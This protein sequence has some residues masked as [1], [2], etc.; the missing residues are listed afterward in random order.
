MNTEPYESTGTNY[1]FNGLLLLIIVIGVFFRYQ[2]L[3]TDFWLDE[4]WALSLLERVSSAT[5]IITTLHVDNNHILSSLSSYLIGDTPDW[6][7]Y[8]L[9]ALVAG[10]LVPVLAWAITS[11]LSSERAGAAFSFS[12]ALWS[13]VPR[14]VSF[15]DEESADEERDASVSSTCSVFRDVD[16][17]LGVGVASAGP[18]GTEFRIWVSWFRSMLTQLSVLNQS[19]KKIYR[20]TVLCKRKALGTGE[21][22][23]C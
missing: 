17:L 16:R 3:L 22:S 1:C 5:G 20:C 7:L 14:R 13:E 23:I 2:G 6:T 21:K 12:S 15:C 18:R 4:I 8:R 11:T 9:P 19:K 10:I